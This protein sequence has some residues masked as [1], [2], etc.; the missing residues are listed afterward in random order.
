MRQFSSIFAPSHSTRERARSRRR[1]PSLVRDAGTRPRTSPSPARAH[2]PKR[3]AQRLVQPHA[4]VAAPLRHVILEHEKISG[5]AAI[6]VKSLPAS[7]SA[8]IRRI[9]CPSP[10]DISAGFSSP[11]IVISIPPALL[12]LSQVVQLSPSASAGW[13]GMLAVTYAAA[14]SLRARRAAVRAARGRSARKARR[15]LGARCPPVS[16]GRRRS[17]SCS[18]CGVD[19]S[20]PIVA[21]LLHAHGARLRLL[22]RGRADRRVLLHRLGLR[23]GQA[24][25]DRSGRAGQRVHYAGRELSLGKKIAIVFIGSFTISAAALILLVSSRVSTTLE[26]PGHH[27]RGRSLPARLSTTRTSWPSRRVRRS[28]RCASTS[29][30]TTRC[31]SSTETESCTSTKDEPLDAGRSRGH[32]PHPQ[33]RQHAPSSART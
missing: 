25:A 14:A 8:L 31:T 7:R 6:D 9:P 28:T 19:S 24:P 29:R 32:P 12:F 26:T 11:P 33:R 5:R 22:P 17:R 10:A 15:S 30:P 23:D 2:S 20:S 16:T 18:G 21:A 4:A 27:L 3:A 1:K 13:C